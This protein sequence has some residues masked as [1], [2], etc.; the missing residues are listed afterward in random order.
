VVEGQKLSTT[1]RLSKTDL[2]ETASK[3]RSRIQKILFIRIARV[4]RVVG[5]IL[6]RMFPKSVVAAAA[7]ALKAS[8]L[9][10]GYDS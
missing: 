2:S 3:V 9:P 6:R 7:E 8:D 5:S 4:P 1:P 10:P